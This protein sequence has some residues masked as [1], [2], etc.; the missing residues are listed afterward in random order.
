MADKHFIPVPSDN[1][2]EA[3]RR[4]DAANSIIAALSVLSGDDSE[5]Q[6]TGTLMGSA[7]YGVG[8]L[9]DDAQKH[10]LAKGA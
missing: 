3:T 6:I 2:N 1:F 7:L 10:L 5:L 9:L 8:I 4:L